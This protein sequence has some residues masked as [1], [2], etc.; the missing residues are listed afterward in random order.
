MRKRFL[1]IMTTIV[2]VLTMV[3]AAAAYGT[4]TQTYNS[5]VSANG[6]T[7]SVNDESLSEWYVDAPEG[8]TLR[9]FGSGFSVEYWTERTLS[10]WQIYEW[11][12]VEDEYGE[13]YEDWILYEAKLLSTEEMLD[14]SL[15]AKELKIEAVWEGPNAD[16]YSDVTFDI[17]GGEF[18]LSFGDNEPWKTNGWMETLKE[19]ALNNGDNVGDQ[20]EEVGTKIVSDPVRGNGE[21]AFEGW[22]KFNEHMISV[23]EYEYELASEEIYST[24]KIM[25]HEIPEDGIYYVAK[26]ADTEIAEYVEYFTGAGAAEV[27]VAFDANGG[28]LSIDTAEGTVE[29]ESWD[30]HCKPGDSIG[31]YISGLDASWEYELLGWD[32]YNQETGGF[33]TYEMSGS[34]VLDY[35]VG[36]DSVIFVARWDEGSSGG[37]TPHVEFDYNGG[38]VTVGEGEDSWSTEWD[39]FE[40]LEDADVVEDLI[41]YD[42]GSV[43]FWDGKRALEGW[44]IYTVQVEQNEDW[45]EENRVIAKKCVTTEEM[46]AYELPKDGNSLEIKAVWKGDDNDY[47]T[48]LYLEGFGGLIETVALDEDGDWTETFHSNWF[49][50]REDNKTV[51]ENLG[52]DIMKDPVMDDGERMNAEFEGW[53][54]Y[55]IVPVKTGDAVLYSVFELDS[56]KLYTTKEIIEQKVPHDDVCYAAKWSDMTIE[57]CESEL[58]MYDPAYLQ[59]EY[60]FYDTDGVL[61]CMPMSMK[62]DGKSTYKQLLDRMGSKIQHMEGLDFVG[63]EYNGDMGDLGDSIM[64]EVAVGTWMSGTAIYDGKGVVSVD[65]RYTDVNGDVAWASV[66]VIFEYGDTWQKA[67]DEALAQLPGA[68]KHDPACSWTGK[69]IPDE[70]LSEKIPTN[71][72][73]VWLGLSAEY[74]KTKVTIQYTYRTKTGKAKTIIKDE[75]LGSDMTV[76]DYFENLTLPDDAAIPEGDI[77]W[78]VCCDGLDLE[79]PSVLRGFFSAA[80]NYDGYDVAFVNRGLVDSE[81]DPCEIYEDAYYVPEN[82]QDQDAVNTFLGEAVTA[83]DK[84]YGDSY[85]D[86]QLK[87]YKLYDIYFDPEVEYEGFFVEAPRYYMEAEYDKALIVLCK[88]DGTEE[89]IVKN[90]GEYYTLP[91]VDGNCEGVWDMAAPF[92]G[93]AYTQSGKAVKADSPYRIFTNVYKVDIADLTAV[94]ENVEMTLD[95]IKGAMKA[96]SAEASGIADSRLVVEYKDV[97]LQEI[98][99]SSEETGNEWGEINPFYFPEGGITVYL[100]YPEGTSAATHDFTVTHMLTG[101]GEAGEIEILDVTETEYGLKVVMTSMSPVAIAYEQSAGAGMFDAADDVR[102]AGSNRYSTSAVISQQI[103]PDNG[104]DAIVIVNGLDFADA[105]AAGTLAEEVGAPI[106]MVNGTNGEIDASVKAEIDR[107]DSNHDAKVYII[108]GQKAVNPKAETAL[109]SMG[110]TAEKIERVFGNNR[111]QTAVKV[112]EKVDADTAFI[113]YGLNFPDALGGG[114]AAMQNDGVILFTGKDALDADTKAYLNKEKFSKIVILGGTGVISPKV[115]NELKGICGN[116]SRVYGK[117]RFATGVAV[118]KE[119]FPKADTIVVAT[120]FNSA[121]ALAGG[122]LASYLG[123]PIVLVDTIN[124]TVS[125]ELKAYIES[126]GVEHIAVLGGEKAISPALYKQL[127]SLLK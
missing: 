12:T 5:I 97:Q 107:I 80:L 85:K 115:E 73:G 53:L 108:G 117:D 103:I 59:V 64:D 127:T 121:D 41:A 11:G 52:I 56:E 6:G 118:A 31:D 54:R 98:V 29:D 24:E 14:Y 4:D 45:I 47:K 39:W 94:P 92:R 96:A 68:D 16:Y 69:W 33:E 77:T 17:Y 114:S 75:V 78:S 46:L 123:A 28:L 79:S 91:L 76:R 119:F 82:L 44:D 65:A 58:N 19:S 93:G 25:T 2:M 34:D 120:G 50:L 86:F 89:R 95:E 124:N 126:A 55:N 88:A 48:E 81:G 51:K 99:G 32:L 72:L 110:Y 7:I 13:V 116:V 37:Y 112:A 60:W 27:D 84:E 42:P 125:P 9:D 90:A 102:L 10:G 71:D 66:P 57:D 61:Q 3:P 105:L 113:A 106:L 111:F 67:Y 63:W 20:L 104:A 70:D 21:V 30:F 35:V 40:I 26:W 49:T 74:E 101:M 23:D 83:M 87:G 36:N 1:A 62:V 15:P 109:K 38:E 122:P 18:E 8:A 43:K 100:P 22:L